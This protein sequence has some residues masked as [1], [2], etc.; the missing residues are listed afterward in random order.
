M[1][2]LQWNILHSPY[3]PTR[4]AIRMFNRTREV[5]TFRDTLENMPQWYIVSGPVNSGKSTLIREVVDRIK[6][7]K[8]RTP[9]VHLDLRDRTFRDT[10]SF[11]FAMLNELS[12]WYEDITNSY[13]EMGVEV[14][15]GEFGAGVTF[16]KEDEDLEPTKKLQKLF[17]KLSKALPNWNWLRGYD[18]PPPI[19]VI[20][21]A[22]RL[23]ALL[24]DDHGNRLLNDFFAW[25]VVNTK[26]N[27]RFHVVM[28]SSDS[29][30]HR[31][32]ARYVDSTYFFTFV[33]GH[34][35]LYRTFCR[36]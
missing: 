23:R 21:E 31:W 1:W 14:N 22:N 2:K 29:F 33:I 11:S 9:M 20:V 15:V 30:F 32:I 5:E 24:D 27:H 28:V 8:P 4:I 6:E 36:T 35:L 26:Q 13:N 16:K 34:L 12:T 18:L 19:L 25:V 10:T 3:L 17:V 7:E